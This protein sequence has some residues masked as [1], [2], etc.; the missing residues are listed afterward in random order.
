MNQIK[1]D[2]ICE[3][4]RLSQTN[5]LERMKSSGSGGS[6]LD[7]V[8]VVEWIKTNAA[9]YREHFKCQLAEFSTTDLGEILK[10]L[11]ESKK[12]LDQILEDSPAFAKK[13]ISHKTF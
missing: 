3:I 4:I 11:G 9:A 2:L 7:E 10:I 5:L 8:V 1:T 12:D 13:K 6:D